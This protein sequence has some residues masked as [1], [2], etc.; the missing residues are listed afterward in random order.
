MAFCDDHPAAD[1]SGT[2]GPHSYSDR[3]L[4]QR[5]DDRCTETSELVTGFLAAIDPDDLAERDDESV[6]R[7][8]E[9]LRWRELR[10]LL[11]SHLATE[12]V[13]R[14]EAEARPLLDELERVDL[15]DH[16]EALT[17]GDL[18]SFDRAC[19][20]ALP[21]ALIPDAYQALVEA[22]DTRSPAPVDEFLGSQDLPAIDAELRS[23]LEA[24]D[25]STR[26]RFERSLVLR[27]SPTPRVVVDMSGSDAVIDLTESHDPVDVGV[28]PW[29]KPD[30]ATG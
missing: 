20:R 17:S 28:P 15:F 19:D 26:R 18:P 13:T 3:R 9:K 21:R 25:G 8:A 1:G 12:V 16:R 10:A 24:D 27:K 7:M 5:W 30:A 4:D 29:T 22:I 2:V 23:L 11:V 14:A 6:D